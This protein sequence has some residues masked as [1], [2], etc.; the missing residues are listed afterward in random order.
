[1]VVLPIKFKN[2][3]KK[4]LCAYFLLQ[5]SSPFA[6]GQNI[7]CVA[8]NTT[9]GF[10]GDGGQATAAELYNPADMVVDTLGNIF[11]SDYWNNRI[12][13]VGTTGI[14]TTIAGN[15]TKGYSG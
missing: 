2:T 4:L 7:N 12:R 15:G 6:F 11:I 10:S 9:S 14:I 5:I 13:K 1:M 3:M 8:G